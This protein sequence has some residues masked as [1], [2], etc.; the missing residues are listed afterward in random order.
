MPLCALALIADA[1]VCFCF[2]SSRNKKLLLVSNKLIKNGLQSQ[3]VEFDPERGR[4]SHFIMGIG[5]HSGGRG[6]GAMMVFFCLRQTDAGGRRWQVAG[7]QSLSFVPPP[8]LPAASNPV[9]PS[10]PPLCV[11]CLRRLHT[12]RQRD[13]T[14]KP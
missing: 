2:A 6:F 9:W 3:Q 14:S 5:R 11:N 12:H 8:H 7:G 10:N 13:G 4:Q 1:P